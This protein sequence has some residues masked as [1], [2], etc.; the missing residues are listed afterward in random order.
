MA[1]L[2]DKR[3]FIAVSSLATPDV[4]GP[5][6]HERERKPIGRRYR[7]ILSSAEETR[8]KTA[9]IYRPQR[10]TA[11]DNGLPATC[12]RTAVYVQHRSGDVAGFSE[13]NDSLGNVLLLRNHTHGRESLHK[14]A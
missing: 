10:A 12:V 3:M 1:Q 7:S 6:H 9:A 14:V 4:H 5:S 2:P 11:S 13:V 8:L